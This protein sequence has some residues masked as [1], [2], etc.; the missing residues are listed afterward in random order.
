MCQLFCRNSSFTSMT[1]STNH[2]PSLIN[3]LTSAADAANANQWPLYRPNNNKNNH[4]I[5]NF[6]NWKFEVHVELQTFQLFEAFPHGSVKLGWKIFLN[7]FLFN[8]FS[9][10]FFK[11]LWTP[12]PFS[13]LYCY[14]FSTHLIVTKISIW[15]DLAV[16]IIFARH[17][18]TLCWIWC[19]CEAG[20]RKKRQHRQ[21]EAVNRY[22][23]NS[24][25]KKTRKI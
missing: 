3:T 5:T 12:T 20:K 13:I 24:Q 9:I 21:L 2:V 19:L 1:S 7:S 18:R 15:T 14:N 6:K 10:S 22:S 8:S 4:K 16:L 11:P 25:Q 23:D 17:P